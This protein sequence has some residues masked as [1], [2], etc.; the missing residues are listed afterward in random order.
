MQFLFCNQ[1]MFVPQ[2]SNFCSLNED[3]DFSILHLSVSPENSKSVESENNRNS[4]RVKNSYEEV[5]DI[6]NFTKH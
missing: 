3:F 1:A 2:L 5:L 6:N 4:S